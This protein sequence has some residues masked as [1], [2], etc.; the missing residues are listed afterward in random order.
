MRAERFFGRTITRASE[1]GRR[2]RVGAERMRP[3]SAITNIVMSIHGVMTHDTPVHGRFLMR[4]RTH[5]TTATIGLLRR[6][7]VAAVAGRGID[8]RMDALMYLNESVVEIIPRHLLDKHLL[9]ALTARN[10]YH[11]TSIVTCLTGNLTVCLCVD[12]LID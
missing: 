11:T 3:A 9:L 4:K 12:P 7:K 8:T 1:C 10:R 6:R 5:I 2:M